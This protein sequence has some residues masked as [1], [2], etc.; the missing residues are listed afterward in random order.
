[1]C[2]LSHS[3]HVAHTLLTVHNSHR[4]P[5]P[6]DTPKSLAVALMVTTETW[7]LGKA[8]RSETVKE[9]TASFFGASDPDAEATSRDHFLPEFVTACRCQRR[10]KKWSGWAPRLLVA[11]PR[12]RSHGQRG[13]RLRMDDCGGQPLLQQPAVD[14]EQKR[15]RIT[16]TSGPSG[17][18]HAP[19]KVFPM[20]PRDNGEWYWRCSICGADL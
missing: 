9:N 2:A 12:D 8:A 16:S 17:C 1:M 18:R 5:F 19:Q 4:S 20:G 7:R 15:R 6:F 10:L 3:T 14:A 13:T 11:P